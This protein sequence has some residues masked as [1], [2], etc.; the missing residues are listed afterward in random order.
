MS[1]PVNT[2]LSPNNLETYK[3]QKAHYFFN[4]GVGIGLFI[5]VMAWVLSI[6]RGTVCSEFNALSDRPTIIMF[7]ERETQITDSSAKKR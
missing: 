6:P 3:S 5:A 2:L 4:S 7:R 1:T